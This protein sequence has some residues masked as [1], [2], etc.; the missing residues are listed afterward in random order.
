M[1]YRVVCYYLYFLLVKF[2]WE[3]LGM[4]IV[5]SIVVL[6]CSLHGGGF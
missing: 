3:K 2:G 5:L 6:R 1:Y 4:V